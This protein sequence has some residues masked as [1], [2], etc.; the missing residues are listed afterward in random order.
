MLQ[1]PRMADKA[2]ICT[3]LRSK[4]LLCDSDSSES[5]MLSWWK[6]SVTAA[7]TLYVVSSDFRLGAGAGARAGTGAEY[8]GYH[9][10]CRHYAVRV[11]VTDH[12][13]KLS[14]FMRDKMGLHRP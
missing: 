14:Q 8:R 1:L 10:C 6:M 9:Q 4:A 5:A 13:W 3:A 11:P 12:F 2:E 7:F